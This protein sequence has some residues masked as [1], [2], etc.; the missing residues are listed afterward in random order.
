[1][2][3]QCYVPSSFTDVTKSVFSSLSLSGAT[4]QLSIT[5]PRF[6]VAKSH[7]IRHA[8]TQPA[9]LLWES[10]Q[11]VVEG[12]TYTTYNKHKIWSSM[13]SVGFEPATPSMKKLQTYALV[14]T[15][16]GIGW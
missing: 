2:Y 3:M 16:T 13:P 9:G 1:M 7:T 5:P 8:H 4:A 14:R 12:A 15:A 6:G 10:D 11:P